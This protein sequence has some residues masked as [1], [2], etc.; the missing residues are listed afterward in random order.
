MCIS[1]HEIQEKWE[2]QEGDFFFD[3]KYSHVDVM[4]YPCYK[5]DDD[6]Y[7]YWWI[8]RI[9]QLQELSGEVW[10]RYYKGIFSEHWSLDSPSIEV[11]GIKYVMEIKYSKRWKFGE[12]LG[13]STWK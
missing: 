4:T 13:R 3:G 10:A 1:A 6:E 12:I 8:P 11:S 9:D 5:P 7:G 2:P